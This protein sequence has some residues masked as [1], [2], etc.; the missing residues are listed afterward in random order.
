MNVMLTCAGRRNYL[1][2]F[3]QEALDGRGKVLAGDASPDASALQE[4][5]GA[6]VLPLVRGSG[7]FDALLAICQQHKVD[8]LISLNDIELPLLARERA[9][10]LEV[11][12]LPVVSSPHVVDMCFDKWATI[13]SLKG[14]NVLVPNTYCSL[15]EARD[16][17]FRGE[18]AFP[19]V[20][21][22]RWGTASIG[23][24]YPEDD[25]ELE[26]AYRLVKKRL[27]RSFLAEASAG[28][29]ERCILIQERLWGHEY[30]LDVVNDLDGGY[31]CTFVKR[32]LAMRAGETDRAISVKNEGLE[33]LGQTIGQRL[34]HVG[35]LDCDVF[36]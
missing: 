20:V 30:G 11:G 33:R 5:D 15:S 10:F 27:E 8:L 19:L 13:N 9:R 25:E 12:T 26:L 6:F 14:W 1:I 34:G 21:K 23:I 35:N 7:Y 29:P 36:A 32:K 24:E 17:L 4:A 31:V 3:F 28:D 2:E 22:P 16:G 18:V